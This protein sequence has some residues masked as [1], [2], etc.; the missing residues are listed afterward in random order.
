MK[1]K[2]KKMSRPLFL[3]GLEDA[4]KLLRIRQV[5][6]FLIVALF[7]LA[8]EGVWAEDKP[9]EDTIRNICD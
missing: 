9:K 6:C 4:K 5:N 3:G 8:A 7:A 1:I 2:I